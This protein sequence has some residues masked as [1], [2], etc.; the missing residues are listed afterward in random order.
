MN[1]TFSSLSSLY[2]AMSASPEVSQPAKAGKKSR[3]A[4]VRVPPAQDER[5]EAPDTSAR[6]WA[7]WESK[8]G[9]SSE[10]AK[11]E[12]F[13]ATQ[14]YL[15]KNGA[16]PYGKYA[17]SITANGV[18]VVASELITITG[19]GEGAIRQ[20]MRGRLQDTVECGRTNMCF[21]NDDSL[22]GAAADYGLAPEQAWLLGDWLVPSNP[23]LTAEEYDIATSMRATNIK[24]ANANQRGDVAKGAGRDVLTVQE[25]VESPRP[26][27]AEET[28]FRSSSGVASG[29]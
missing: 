12:V 3:W 8:F 15:T 14:L 27:V 9:A 10:A 24:R 5:S 22:R 2:D 18:A 13:V 23:W 19:R 20:F 21:R 1:D 16:S 26:R 7:E 6:H 25:A 29:F 28:R 4:D 17:R 11:N